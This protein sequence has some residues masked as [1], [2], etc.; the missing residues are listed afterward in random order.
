MAIVT[1][2]LTGGCVFTLLAQNYYTPEEL[3]E[4]DSL[5]RAVEREPTLPSLRRLVEPGVALVGPVIACS[6]EHYGLLATR[7]ARVGV[8][9]IVD[10][11]VQDAILSI[12]RDERQGLGEPHP[13]IVWFYEAENWV[14]YRNVNGE[15]YGGGRGP[16]K[17]L[18]KAFVK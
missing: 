16:E 13:L 10:R 4:C 1:A 6:H 8:W 14:V 18:R 17:L 15:I 3:L 11:R 7:Y 9:G 12:L 2:L 5:V